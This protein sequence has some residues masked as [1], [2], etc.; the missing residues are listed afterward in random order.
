VVAQEEVAQRPV[1]ET[2]RTAVRVVVRT[3]PEQDQEMLEVIRRSKVT[4]AVVELM[5]TPQVAVAEL[6]Q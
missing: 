3:T 1:E 5:V 6:Q 2:E 4:P